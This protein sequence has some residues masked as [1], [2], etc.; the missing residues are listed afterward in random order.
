MRQGDKCIQASPG[1]RGING[2]GPIF[3]TG[4]GAAIGM[5]FDGRRTSGFGG[6]GD[7]GGAWKFVVRTLSAR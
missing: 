2:D 7:S 6:G 3:G 4:R 5:T 1:G